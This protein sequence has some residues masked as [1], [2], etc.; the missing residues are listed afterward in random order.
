MQ[1]SKDE[2]ALLLNQP[3]PLILENANL[4]GAELAEADLD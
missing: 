1:F 4:E 3:K 2:L